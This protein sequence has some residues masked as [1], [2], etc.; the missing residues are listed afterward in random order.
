MKNEPWIDRVYKEKFQSFDLELN[1]EHWAQAEALITAH[2]KRKNRDRLILWVLFAGIISIVGWM[3]QRSFNE[4]TGSPITP[5]SQPAPEIEIS[6]PAIAST[7]DLQIP[8]I[9]LSNTQNLSKTASMDKKINETRREVNQFAKFRSGK[10]ISSLTNEK[11]N[12]T[13]S[14]D[15]AS[16]ITPFNTIDNWSNNASNTPI[17]NENS[18]KNRFINIIE[19]NSGIKPLYSPI[20]PLKIVSSSDIHL[21]IKIKRSH[22]RENGVGAS[23]AQRANINN[24]FSVAQAGIEWYQNRSISKNL[25]YGFSIGYKSDFN[26][27]YYAQVIT[28][29][30]FEG[31]GSKVENYGLKPNW[32]QYGYVKGSLG[33]EVKK[34]RFIASLRPEFLVA[35]KGE[36]NQMKFNDPSGNKLITQAQISSYNR[37]WLQS[38]LMNKISITGTIAYEYRVMD[39]IGIGFQINHIIR[40]PYKPLQSGFVQNAFSR[41]NSGFR[42][43]YI[44]N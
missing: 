33:V 25:F 42:V 36:V 34:H 13:N 30:K 6:N 11:S 23:L 19:L 8:T 21:P 40:S 26:N 28:Q 7:F 38:N 16:G 9:K 5:S 39:K 20:N 41:W 3:M 44:L 22:W 10:S 4:K 15:I 24:R 31:F 27:D 37:G 14:G 35:T 32:L 29:H 1:S 17:S 12:Q 2:D 18:R 43:S